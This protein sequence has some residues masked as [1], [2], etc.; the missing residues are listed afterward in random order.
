ML[1]VLVSKPVYLRPSVALRMAKSR[2]PLVISNPV[3]LPERSSVPSFANVA[4]VPANKLTPLKLNV[5]KLA[6]M[7][8]AGSAS[9][10]S[11]VNVLSSKL[12]EKSPF[13]EMNPSKLRLMLLLIS[14]RLSGSK[15]RPVSM[16]RLLDVLNPF[17]SSRL[18][19]PLAEPNDK[20]NESRRSMSKPLGSPWNAP[21]KLALKPV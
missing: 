20:L 10:S 21:G 17:Q 3:G 13:R 14:L 9:G 8:V 19:P 7:V 18:P 2:L 1:L 4:P 16:L 15:S 12:M 5:S 6:S 11:N